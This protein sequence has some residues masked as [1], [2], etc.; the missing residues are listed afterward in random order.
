MHFM[1]N[2]SVLFV[3]LWGVLSVFLWL[4][5]RF[6]GFMYTY[7]CIKKPVFD[8]AFDRAFDHPKA[9]KSKKAVFSAFLFR[10]AWLSVLCLLLAFSALYVKCFLLFPA[11]LAR[12]ASQLNTKGAI[13][14]LLT[15]VT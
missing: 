8:R 10:V 5:L 6:S 7:M 14:P 13:M 1:L 11:L 2:N 3:A 12:L 4:L 15:P 9:K